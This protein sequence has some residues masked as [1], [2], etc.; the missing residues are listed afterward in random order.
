M[1]TPDVF[2]VLSTHYF[3]KV[4]VLKG[5]V[6]DTMKLP[7]YIYTVLKYINLWKQANNLKSVNWCA[8]LPKPSE[9]SFLFSISTFPSGKLKCIFKR[10]LLLVENNVAKHILKFLYAS[11]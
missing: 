8:F 2:L 11:S 4:T 3:T 1:K 9:I 5:I 7:F 6:T 10:L